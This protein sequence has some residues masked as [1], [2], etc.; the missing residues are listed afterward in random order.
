MSFDA[1]AW[2]AV[3]YRPWSVTLGEP[4]GARGPW[5]YTARELSVL[6]VARF[7]EAY[8]AAA[9]APVVRLRLLRDFFRRLFP[10]VF[11]WRR[12]DPVALILALPDRAREALLIDFFAH[13]AG[14]GTPRPGPSTSPTPSTSG[15]PSNEPPSA[16]RPT[17]R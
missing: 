8:H 12:P 1:T 13:R 5:T 3:H 15:L 16:R 11:W 2:L 9:A 7:Q 4:D 10:G 6:E 17:T 14:R